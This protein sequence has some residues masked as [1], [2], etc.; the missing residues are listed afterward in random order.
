MAS[1]PDINIL[2]FIFHVVHHGSKEPFLIDET[3]V[4]GF[5][6]F[7]IDRIREIMDG[8][9]FGFE[10][11]S[12]FL[13]DIRVIDNNPKKFVEISKELARRFHNE[14]GRIKAGVM[15]L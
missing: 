11:E 7:F 2:D 8:N 12:Q 10:K 14:D 9:S 1:N 6:G 4:K 5:E 3:P 13:N 15:I